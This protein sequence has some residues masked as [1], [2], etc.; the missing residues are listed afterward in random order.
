[1]ELR[2]PGALRYVTPLAGIGLALALPAL[3]RADQPSY[4]IGP[5]V[6]K[7]HGTIYELTGRTTL[8]IEDDRGFDDSVTLRAGALILPAGLALAP[9]QGVTILGHTDGKTFAADEVD[10]DQATDSSAQAPAVAYDY[11]ATDPNASGY[12]A[13]AFGYDPGLYG[14]YAGPYGNPYYSVVAPGFF[15]GYGGGGSYYVNQPPKSGGGER[16][17]PHRPVTVPPAKIPPGIYYPTGGA[18][19]SPVRSSA[20]PPA[21]A[22]S[23]PSGRTR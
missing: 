22:A 8:T 10:I 3:T 5:P 7:I 15:Y 21:H 20:Q 18:R 23:A 11:S 13:Y 12:P 6:E 17:I 2:P 9:G 14:G 1:M 16:T 4:A 19:F